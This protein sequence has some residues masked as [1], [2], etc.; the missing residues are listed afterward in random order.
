MC[1]FCGIVNY[2]KDISN[3]NQIIKNMTTTLISRGPDE[4][5]FF[6]NKNVNL[7]HRRLIVI[8]PENGTQPMSFNFQGNIYT[9]VFNGQIYNTCLL[10]TSRC[11]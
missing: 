8:D 1:G 7:G 10:Y 6:L 11:V 9:I 4:G 3:N 5:G 2:N